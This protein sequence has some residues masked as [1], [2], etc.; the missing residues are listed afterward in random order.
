MHRRLGRECKQAFGI[1][2]PVLER[3]IAEIQNDLRGFRDRAILLIT[4]DSLLRRSELVSLKM[5]DI[6]CDTDGLPIYIRL[7]KSKT[8]QEAI[9][10][11]IRL[12]MKSKVAI[13]SWIE[14]A[15][16]TDGL[17]FRGVKNDGDITQGISPGQ[18]NRIYKRLALRANI[19]N[20]EI[21]GHSIRVGA[22]QDL[23]NMG[24]SL[25][26]LMNSGG[27]SKPETAM[28]YAEAMHS[29][30]MELLKIRK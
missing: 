1:T 3:I 23:V 16:I 28:R 4:Y 10:R 14:K 13:K 17:L 12:T 21:S 30:S 27:W 22:A 7:R 8:D 20:K 25:P 2:A 15:K 24:A 6:E 26:V 11:V 19:C 29:N 9:G 18:I 5:D